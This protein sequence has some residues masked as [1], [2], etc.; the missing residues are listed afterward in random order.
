MSAEPPG[1]QRRLPLGRWAVTLHWKCHVRIK[2]A[3]LTDFDSQLI[4]GMEEVVAHIK[5]EPNTGRATV[6]GFA[7]AKSIREGL[8]MSQAV[9][10]RA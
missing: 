3:A 8:G 7:D 2:N 4:A 5:G 10:A 1:G 6:V 9:F